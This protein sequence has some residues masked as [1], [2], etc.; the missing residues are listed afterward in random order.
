ML[1]ILILSY[2]VKQG[3]LASPILAASA[4]QDTAPIY[5]A[6]AAHT[7]TE[8]NIIWSCLV[9]IISCT[10]I[11]IHP[12]IPN[13]EDSSFRIA[14]RRAHIMLVALIAPELI[15]IV[16]ARQWLDARRLAQAYRVGSY[17]LFRQWKFAPLYLL[18]AD[19]G[20]T[21]SHAFFALMGG[22]MFFDG[23]KPLEALHPQEL[24]WL[25]QKGEIDFPRISEREIKDKSK[26]DMISKG[27]VA[28]QT[29]WFGLQCTARRI[30]HLPITQLELATASFAFLN[31][32][33]YILWWNKPL[34][35]R[36][37]FP[38]TWKR[39]PEGA[40]GV[41]GVSEA[42]GLR[43]EADCAMREAPAK[44]FVSTLLLLFSAA[45]S[46]FRTAF[47]AAVSGIKD[48]HEENIRFLGRDP[49][50]STDSLIAVALCPAIIFFRFCDATVLE[51]SHPVELPFTDR[52]RCNKLC[53]L[54]GLRPPAVEPFPTKR[55]ETEIQLFLYLAVSTIFGG[56]HC[57]GWSY[58]FPSHRE[59]MLWRISS[60]G[61]TV[62]PIGSWLFTMIAGYLMHIPL[63]FVFPMLALQ[64]PFLVF[65]R[66]T[67]LILAIISLRSLPPGAYDTVYWTTRIPHL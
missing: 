41:T 27:L 53:A 19:Y 28:A 35:V 57:F 23:E 56:I 5:A 37:P 16:A 39:E 59:E 3:T 17:K 65:A 6:D 21:Q 48:F 49:S 31:I 58:Q 11:A 61:I 44:D 20:W 9:T 62:F 50:R 15:T 12:N 45:V 7:R 22:F 38:V 64:I 18:S 67:L 60:L 43:S 52:D 25:S 34:N 2:L 55:L 13:P 4:N 32:V 54:T 42:C 29:T 36:C 66:I 26:G 63:L 40:R 1:L 10:W 46:P 24:R 33:T 47:A 14:L 8:W 30:Q 51:F